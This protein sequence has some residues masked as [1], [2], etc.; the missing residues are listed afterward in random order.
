LI[1]AGAKIDP[2]NKYGQT[3]LHYAIAF[4]HP[5]AVQ[6]LLDAGADPTVKMNN[7]LN[8]IKLASRVN[9]EHITKLLTARPLTK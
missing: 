8:A 4:K 6:H 9:H 7:G 5:E 3:P 1:H 2:K